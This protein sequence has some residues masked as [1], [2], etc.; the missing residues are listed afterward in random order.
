MGQNTAVVH[1]NGEAEVSKLGVGG[2]APAAQQSKIN[3]PTDLPSCITAITAILDVLEA[4]GL[5]ASA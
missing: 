4:F 3:D 1:K 5:S 2:V